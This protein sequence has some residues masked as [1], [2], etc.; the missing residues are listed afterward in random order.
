MKAWK[1]PAVLML[2][3]AQLADHVYAAATSGICV[4]AYAR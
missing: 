3:A 2:S 1:K 4:N